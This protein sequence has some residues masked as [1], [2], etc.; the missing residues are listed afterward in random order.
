MSIEVRDV[1]IKRGDRTI[2]QEVSF[3]VEPGSFLAIAG[4]NGCGKSTLLAGI[5]NELSLA[6]GEIFIDGTP[7][8]DWPLQALAKRRAVLLQDSDLS[9]PFTVLDV[10]LM[11]RSAFNSGVE[12]PRDLEVAGAAL[13]RVG[14]S[15]FTTRRYTNLSGGERQR[16]HL[17]RVLAQVWQDEDPAD[18]ASQTRYLLLDEPTASQDLAAQHRVLS[19]AREFADRGGVVISV[20]HDL[21][22][23]AQYAD[24]V[25]LLS[26]S[27]VVGLG[28]PRDVLTPTTLESVYGVPIRVIEHR[29]LSHPLIISCRPEPDTAPSP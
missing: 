22:Q 14:L 1:A 25:V 18:S 10:V 17:A 4:V 5:S 11:G 27:R 21:N 20:L 8:R 16:V 13:E 29:G 19:S 12:T 23:V 7:L 15:S 9:F 28:S 26:D 3:T 2:V 6:S 24:E